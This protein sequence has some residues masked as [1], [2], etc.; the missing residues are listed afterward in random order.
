MQLIS[1]KDNS[2]MSLHEYFRKIWKCGMSVM[3][4]FQSIQLISAQK[5]SQLLPLVIFYVE[6]LKVHPLNFLCNSMNEESLL[7]FKY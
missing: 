7:Y 6:P 3:H 5:H 4:F 1:L 2:K